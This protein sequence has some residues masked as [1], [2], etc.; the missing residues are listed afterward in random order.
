[1]FLGAARR[2]PNEGAMTALGPTASPEA[3]RIM[4]MLSF[5]ILLTV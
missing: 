4:H 3:P 2:S 1:L 5:G